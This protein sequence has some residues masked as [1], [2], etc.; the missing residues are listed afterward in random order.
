MDGM[1]NAIFKKI[2]L[3]REYDTQVNHVRRFIFK[4]DLAAVQPDNLSDNRQSQTAAAKLFR[5]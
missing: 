1:K 5:A 3:K 4:R 2:I